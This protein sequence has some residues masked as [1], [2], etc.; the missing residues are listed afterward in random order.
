MKIWT[1]TTIYLH[2]NQASST[3]DRWEKNKERRRQVNFWWCIILLNASFNWS[4][5]FRIL[6][7]LPARG[8][9][10]KMKKVTYTAHLLTTERVHSSRSW[11]WLTVQSDGVQLI[12]S[13]EPAEAESEEWSATLHEQRKTLLAGTDWKA[14]INS[15]ALRPQSRK[16]ALPC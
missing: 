6:E 16:M 1:R 14:A 10:F 8:G 15:H 5:R 2:G 3:D 12:F 4:K 11:V 7:S 9:C 13:S